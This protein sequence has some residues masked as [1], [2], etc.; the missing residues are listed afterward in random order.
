[1]FTELGKGCGPIRAVFNCIRAGDRPTSGNEGRLHQADGSSAVA[2]R[3]QA[4]P[5]CAVQILSPESETLIT[6]PRAGSSGMAA[7]AA[8]NGRGRAKTFGEI[9]VQIQRTAR[10]GGPAKQEDLITTIG[11]GHAG[12]LAWAPGLERALLPG[13]RGGGAWSKPG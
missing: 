11:R 3:P 10:N 13:T 2:E 7:R 1:M 6:R 4:G 9:C 5:R 8:R 12:R